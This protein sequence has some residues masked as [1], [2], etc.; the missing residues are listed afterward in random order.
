[1]VEEKINAMF[2]HLL[3]TSK[4]KMS[5]YTNSSIAFF[6]AVPG[7]FS[8]TDLYRNILLLLITFRVINYGIETRARIF[9]RLWS[10]GIDFKKSFLPFYVAQRAG[11][12]TLFLLGSSPPYNVWK[13]QL[14]SHSGSGNALFRFEAK[15]TQVKRSEKFEAKISEKKRKRRS[16]IL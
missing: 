7:I 8:L 2:P 6:P 13:F 16:E 14:S 15:I 10:P 3:L 12:I 11:T 1:V 9:K 4:K 5:G